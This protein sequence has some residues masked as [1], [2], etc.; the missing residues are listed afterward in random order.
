LQTAEWIHLA[1]DAVQWRGLVN[2]IKVMRVF[3]F[4]LRQAVS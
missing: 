3:G 2:T 1:Q 4:L